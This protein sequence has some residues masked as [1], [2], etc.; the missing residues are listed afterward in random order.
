LGNWV[1]ADDPGAAVSELR[2]Q[3]KEAVVARNVAEQ[4]CAELRATLARTREDLEALRGRYAGL[5]VAAG[6]REA[7]METLRIGVAELLLESDRG[8]PQGDLAATAVRALHDLHEA[9]AALYAG[10]RQFAD[11]LKGVID[12]LQPS[13]AVRREIGNR[14]GRLTGLASEAERSPSLVAWRGGT[15]GR[16]RREGRV[17]AVNDEFQLVILD[18]GTADGAGLGMLWTIQGAE[19]RVTHVVRLV[20]SRLALSAAVPIEGEIESIAP[21]MKVQA[22]VP[23]GEK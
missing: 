3:L 4:R 12:A 7:E 14:M 22:G 15:E 6:Q 2:A 8:A 17:L 13:V 20:D 21:G 23:A 16:S 5:L 11:Y 9:N 18:V 19:G 1:S 10:V